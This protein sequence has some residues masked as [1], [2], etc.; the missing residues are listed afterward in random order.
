MFRVFPQ[1]S[2]QDKIQIALC[3]DEYNLAG[4]F[5]TI[6]SIIRNSSDPSRLEFFV[7]LNDIH[8][9]DLIEQYKNK[10]FGNIS[11]HLDIIRDEYKAKLLGYNEYC[12]DNTHCKNIMNFARFLL[13]D[14]FS[15]L[16]HFVYIDTDYLVLDDIT[17]VWNCIQSEGDIWAVPSEYTNERA[18]SLTPFGKETLELSSRRPFNAG[19]YIVNGERWREKNYTGEFID[20]INNKTLQKCVRFGTQPLLNYVFQNTYT[21]LPTRW[22]RIAYDTNEELGGQRTIDLFMELPKDELILEGVSAIHFAGVPKPWLFTNQLGGGCWPSPNE[23]YKQ[24]L[25]Y[26]STLKLNKV[27]LQKYNTA[28]KE[29]ITIL[30]D[31]FSV[32]VLFI[33]SNEQTHTSK[34]FIEFHCESTP[35]RYKSEE[36]YVVFGGKVIYN[37]SSIQDISLKEIVLN[38][39]EKEDGIYIVSISDSDLY[40]YRKNLFEKVKYLGIV[41]EKRDHLI[42]L[43]HAYVFLE[44][45]C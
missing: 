40:I 11:I 10:L 23:L 13:T 44:F 17:K 26:K 8:L 35:D 5:A 33:D 15:Q 29:F 12:A 38:N 25:P 37:K 30:N 41:E 28:M 32:N 42:Q 45:L 6:N 36:F 1:S 34:K 9:K 27:L 2:M 3:S 22:N 21:E 18:Y 24:Y 31:I 43:L 7:L 20:M 39:K 14:I 4:L 19:I 16:K